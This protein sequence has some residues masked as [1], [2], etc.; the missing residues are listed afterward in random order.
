MISL[1]NCT[2][3]RNMM[4]NSRKVWTKFTSHVC[5][6][7]YMPFCVRLGSLGK[8]HFGLKRATQIELVGTGCCIYG[9]YSKLNSFSTD[10]MYL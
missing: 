8:A 5:V 7:P 2:H 4:K 10:I 9:Q 6:V 1:F 3:I